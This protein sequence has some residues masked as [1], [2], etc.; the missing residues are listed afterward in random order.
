M[1]YLTDGLTFRTLRSAC[2]AR[3]KRWLKKN[4]EPL[5]PWTPSEW[6][7]ALIG[8]LGEFANLHKKVRRGDFTLEEALPELRK[9]LAD[10]QTYLTILADQFDIDL[11]AATIEKFNEV[12]VRIGNPVRIRADGSDWRLAQDPTCKH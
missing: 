2:K 1:G 3:A 6:L 10:V 5:D 12:S 7:E 11:G 9:E 8:E 4:G